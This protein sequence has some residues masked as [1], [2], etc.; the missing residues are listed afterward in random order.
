MKLVFR[1]KFC[2]QYPS[3]SNNFSLHINNL[4]DMEVVQLCRTNLLLGTPTTAVGLKEKLKISQKCRLHYFRFVLTIAQISI[5]AESMML[6][7][8]TK[9]LICYSYFV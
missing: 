7:K 8:M 5:Q 3:Q 2:T 4:P 6:F 9:I 1:D